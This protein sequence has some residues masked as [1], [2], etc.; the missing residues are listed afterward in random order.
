MAIH[1]DG[2]PAPFAGA[3][4][5]LPIRL[6]TAVIPS[7]P[8]QAGAARNLSFLTSA[9]PSLRRWMDI[10]WGGKWFA[11]LSGSPIPPLKNYL[12]KIS[13]DSVRIPGTSGFPPHQ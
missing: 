10:A 11:W 8:A 4:A 9:I 13:A 12:T 7:L 6:Q 1:K 2:L 3:A 5:I